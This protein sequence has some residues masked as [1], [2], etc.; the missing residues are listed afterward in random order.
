MLVCF[1]HYN[2]CKDK[3]N[4][5]FSHSKSIIHEVSLFPF[6]FFV[7]GFCSALIS[8][9]LSFASLSYPLNFCFKLWFRVATNLALLL[10]TLTMLGCG[11]VLT[12]NGRW[13]VEFVRFSFQ[14]K[15]FL[16]NSFL[17]LFFLLCKVFLIFHEKKYIFVLL[18]CLFLVFKNP[19]QTLKWVSKIYWK[20]ATKEVLLSKG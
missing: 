9:S 12:A 17:I 15:S 16:V 7:H 20:F 10:G 19:I 3:K 13:V 2:S 5:F 4:L 6:S 14:N 11:R 8:I 18:D 1:V